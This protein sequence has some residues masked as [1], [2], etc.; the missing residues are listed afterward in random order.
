[1]SR[2]RISKHTHARTHKLA[3]LMESDNRMR[4]S[5]RQEDREIESY[6]SGGIKLLVMQDE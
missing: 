3:K 5:R 6:Y 1:M 4:L 2:T